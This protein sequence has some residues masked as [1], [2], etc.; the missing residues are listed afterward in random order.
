[1]GPAP[2]L[3]WWRGWGAGATAP[4]PLVVLVAWMAAGK[5]PLARHAE[6]YRNLGCEV[7]AVRPKPL[8][9]WLPHRALQLAAVLADGLSEEVHLRGVRPVLL[10]SFSGGAKACTAAFLELMASTP[11][12]APLRACLAG[13]A[14]DSAPVDFL[15]ARGVAFL[16][17]P[18]SPAWRRSLAAAA[19][20]ALDAVALSH[21]ERQRRR[22]WAALE[23]GCGP[24]CP[25]LLLFSED[26][27]LVPPSDVRAFAAALRRGGRA[28]SEQVWPHAAHVGALREHPEAYRRAVRAWLE[29]ACGRWRQ[30]AT[31]SPE[32]PARL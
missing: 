31:G 28:V 26:D 29:Q 17:P 13:E 3:R 10:V 18:G 11:A 30:Q 24:G 19:A 32:L 27:Q 22:Y 12:H 23:A 20:V 15:S 6:L 8:G 5:G 4:P 9:M 14:Y 25:V 16:A 7:V 1:M 2:Q 21:F